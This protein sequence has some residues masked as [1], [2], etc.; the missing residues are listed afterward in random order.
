MLILLLIW[1]AVGLGLAWLVS[2]KRRGSA[3]LPLAYFLGISLIH[4]P[5]AILY[6]DTE[7]ANV[8]RIGFEQT[9]LGMVAFLTGV[10]VARYA[11][12]RPLGQRASAG[13]TEAF[14]PQGLMALDR[15]A[16]LYLSI[17]SI[18]YFI[19][20]PLVG[21]IASAGAV[22]S[23]LGSLIMVGACLRLWVAGKSRNRIKFWSTIA[24]LP[25]LPLATLLQGGFVGFG[26]YWVLAIVAFLFAQSER[27]LRY[28]LLAP[29]VFFVALSLFVNYMAARDEIRQLVWY[30]QAGIGAR[31][32]RIAKVF[33]DFEWLDLSNF[34]HRDAIDG[35][36]NQNQL[37]GLAVERLDMGVVEYASGQTLGTMILGLIPRAVWP[38]KPTIGG[39]GTIVHDFTGLEFQEGTSVGAGQVFEFYVNFGSL[40]VI[41]G[42]LLWGWLCG[43]MDL[44]AI[45]CLR[46]GNQRRFLFWF[47][48]ALTLL[49]SGGNLLE[50]FVS[51]VS[52]AITAYGIGYLLRRR[53]FARN[54]RSLPPVTRAAD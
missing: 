38:D 18:A 50:I 1:I 48:I 53:G 27:R 43:R 7:D 44:R 42:F 22:V 54:V 35:R 32:D 21:G 49:Q 15:L 41:G 13:Q 16:L 28:V 33:N 23:A 6:L 29:A 46:Q 19:L 34:R 31:F 2:Q 10:I 14:T 26:T 37:V 45:E 47:L 17:G 30:E 20:L 52:A 40:G 4:V 9:T 5:G 8:T 12:V 3:G 36:L 25:L 51:A 24:L 39:G 11:F